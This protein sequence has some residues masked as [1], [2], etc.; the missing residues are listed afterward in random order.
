MVQVTTSEGLNWTG[1]VGIVDKEF[2]GDRI[3]STSWPAEGRVRREWVRS[4]LG[5]VVEMNRAHMNLLTRDEATFPFPFFCSTIP[6]FLEFQLL[7][8]LEF[9]KLNKKKNWMPSLFE[10][11]TNKFF[12]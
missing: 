11:Q 1:M 10:F 9:D 3:P 6:C 4:D 12:F 7:F 5:P 2:L 8:Q